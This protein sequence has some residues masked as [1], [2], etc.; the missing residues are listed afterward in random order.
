MGSLK[1]DCACALQRKAP[2]NLHVG[3]DA[4]LSLVRF[5]GKTCGIAAIFSDFQRNLA[6]FLCN[7]DCVAEREGFELS[8]PFL[9]SS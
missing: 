7:P 3:F 2:E 5:E 1:S 6:R 8:V 9:Q 4:T